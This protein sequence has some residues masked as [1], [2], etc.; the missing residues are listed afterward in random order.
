MIEGAIIG[1][2]IGV[3]MVVVFGIIAHFK[4]AS[5]DVKVKRSGVIETAGAPDETIRRIQSS[6]PGAGLKVEEIDTAGHRILLSEGLSFGSFGHF[7]PISAEASAGGARVTVGM[8]TK[9]PQ[10]GPVVS[11][12]HRKIMDKVRGM[13]AA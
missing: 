10:Y 11:R 13:I 9:I 6:A 2:V 12:N 1:G 8:S 7:F 5:F 4:K 3:I